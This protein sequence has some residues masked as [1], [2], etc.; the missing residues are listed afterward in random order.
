MSRPEEVTKISKSWAS[1]VG[2]SSPGLRPLTFAS[3]LLQG[4]SFF[5][6]VPIA[7]WIEFSKSSLFYH[8]LNKKRNPKICG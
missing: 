4:S 8:L 5:S 3:D 7:L 1:E 6:D 2:R